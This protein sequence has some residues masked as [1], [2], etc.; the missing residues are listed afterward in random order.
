MLEKHFST[1]LYG[2]SYHIFVTHSGLES[3][4]VNAKRFLERKI[5]EYKALQQVIERLQQDNTSTTQGARRLFTN[6]QWYLLQSKAKQHTRAVLNL[7][8]HGLT[9]Y[10]PVNFGKHLSRDKIGTF[11][12]VLFPVYVFINLRDE[13][14]WHTTLHPWGKS[15]SQFQRHST[16]C[17]RIAVRRAATT[18]IYPQRGATLFRSGERVVATKGCFK[19][20]EAIIKKA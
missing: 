18:P 15:N 10:A 1:E 20:V 12:E 16:P 6:P 14:K 9:C 19:H 3:N 2:C 4:A 17:A 11:T 13:S 7:N 8:H 5:D